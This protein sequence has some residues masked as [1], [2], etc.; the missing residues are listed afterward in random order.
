MSDGSGIDTD[1]VSDAGWEC[2]GRLNDMLNGISL[3]SFNDTWSIF[4]VRANTIEDPNKEA[5][6]ASKYE[7]INGL[8]PT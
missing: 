8:I 1:R 5:G 6:P 7:I 4:Y 2:F 3:V